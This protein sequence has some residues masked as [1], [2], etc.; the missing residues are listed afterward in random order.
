MFLRCAAWFHRPGTWSK[1]RG[2]IS[3]RSVRKSHRGNTK[4]EDG[5]GIIRAALGRLDARRALGRRPYY[6]SLLAET[7]VRAGHRD[8]ARSAVD[9]ALSRA[10]D[11]GEAWWLPALYQLKSEL[12][13]S[14]GDRQLALS[15]ALDL[16]RAQ[17]SRALEQRILAADPGTLARTLAE[18]PTS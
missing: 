4:P 1:R 2:T 16:A 8:S 18:R 15:H 13:N 11:S 3:E 9:A 7:L 14:V 17:G 10:Q 6:L 5:I 12:A